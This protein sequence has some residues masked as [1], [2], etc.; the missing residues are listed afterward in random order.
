[1]SLAVAGAGLTALCLAVLLVA[2][3]R[4]L[5][6]VA[7]VAKAAASTGFLLVALGLGATRSPFGWLLLA[8]LALSWVGDVLLIPKAKAA[9]LAGL[10]SFLAAHLAYA[11]A[12]AVRGLS[13]WVAVGTLAVLLV[14][15]HLVMRWLAPHVSAGMRLP[16][17]LYALA[18]T[19]MVA[20][21]VGTVAARFDPW[22]LA[23]AVAFYLSDLSVARDRFVAPGF[24]NRLWGLPLYYGG[25]LLLA[26]ALCH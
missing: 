11:G 4:G 19:V 5:R 24:S 8:G 23:G 22:L 14:P 3:A 6:P 9:F 21:A 2:E 13:P 26:L 12:F 25:Q 15:R 17:S 18:I 10:G 1:V 20:G 7:A 16:V